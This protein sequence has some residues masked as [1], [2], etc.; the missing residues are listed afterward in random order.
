MQRQRDRTLWMKI[1]ILVL[2]GI[3]APALHA[4]MAVVDV[5]A[6]AQLLTEVH[7]LEAQL[8]TARDHLQQAQD[9]FRSITGSRG[10]E[11]L[12]SGVPRNYLP[13]DWH[14]IENLAN[15]GDHGDFAT[16]A[17]DLQQAIT[18]NSVLTVAQLAVLTPSAQRQLN[19]ARNA[20]ALLQV[21]TRQALTTTSARFASLQQLIDAIPGASDQKAVLELQARISAE[22]G[23]LQN[24]QTKL[25]ILFRA[26]EA[27]Q[28]ASQQRE[29]EQ[30]IAAH[31]HFSTRFQPTP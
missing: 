15:A 7:T 27:E 3:V 16:L 1:V 11:R 20:A 8:S 28:W 26:A 4:Q 12:L 24:E 13:I 9:E 31:G 23:M 21:L 29:R 17:R 30:A 5:R 18:R 14:G 22:Q 6:V 2:V 25:Q 10:M 19:D